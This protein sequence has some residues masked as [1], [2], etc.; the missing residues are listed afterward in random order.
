MHHQ[1]HCICLT[2]CCQLFTSFLIFVHCIFVS[3]FK[4]QCPLYYI[5]AAT[6]MYLLYV[7]VTTF[8]KIK[9]LQ[10]HVQLAYTFNANFTAYNCNINM[11][12][13]ELIHVYY[14]QLIN[15]LLISL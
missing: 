11:I 4:I 9:N 2:D 5:H 6:Y 14:I 15:E 8:S 10:L 7:N 1:H 12:V 3:L 13:L